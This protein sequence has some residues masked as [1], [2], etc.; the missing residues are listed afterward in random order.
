MS[1]D[2]T[3]DKI[4]YQQ[5]NKK[6]EL[7]DEIDINML[8]KI[9]SSFDNKKGSKNDVNVKILNLIWNSKCDII[10]YMIKNSLKL[11]HV[12]SEW[13]ISKI[14]PI[15]KVIGSNKIEDRRPINTLPVYEQVL[16]EVVKI[17][18]IKFI[19]DNRIINPEQSGFRKGHSCETALQHSIMRWRKN[20]DKGLYTGVVFVDFARAFETINRNKL[21]N[22]L[23]NIG[24]QG[25]VLK[26]LKSYLSE[27]KQRVKFQNCL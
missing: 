22:I 24:I 5:Q 16:E 11:G 10:L 4:R 2:L 17:Q 21:L 19:D 27:R 3:L 6:W 14:T 12:P 8:N 20:L 9:I 7:F 13:K 18:L 25:T 1:Y 26:W 15:Q 23:H